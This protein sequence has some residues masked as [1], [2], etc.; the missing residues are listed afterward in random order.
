[1]RQFDWMTIAWIVWT[2][3]LIIAVLYLMFYP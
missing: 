1:M 3:L 2:G